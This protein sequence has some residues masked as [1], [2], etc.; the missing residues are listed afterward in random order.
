MHTDHEDSEKSLN[1]KTQNS[2]GLR[3]SMSHRKEDSPQ[4]PN[5]L[6]PRR[7]QNLNHKKITTRQKIENKVASLRVSNHLNFNL[8]L[9]ESESPSPDPNQDIHDPQKIMNLKFP[10]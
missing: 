6:S 2:P 8:N 1:L 3:K 7:A 10:I 5:E 9:L 4:G